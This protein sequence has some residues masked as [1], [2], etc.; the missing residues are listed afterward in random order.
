MSYLFFHDCTFESPLN[1]KKLQQKFNDFKSENKG[2]EFLHIAYTRNKNTYTLECGFSFGYKHE[3]I[4]SKF[5]STII[6]TNSYAL[7]D[8]GS[9]DHNHSGY[10]IFHTNPFDAANNRYNIYETKYQP[11]VDNKSIS[12]FA[13][14]YLK[15]LQSKQRGGKK[16]S[17][18][19]QKRKAKSSGSGT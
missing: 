4:I 12:E 10:L 18:S 16:C 15:K 9:E 1:K 2:C 17:V 5:I 6:S 14:Q 13:A 11:T 7:T 3:Y 19:S 8:F